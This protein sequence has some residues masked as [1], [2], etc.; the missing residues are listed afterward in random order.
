[1]TC[2]DC[3]EKYTREEIATWEEEGKVFMINNEQGVRGYLLCPRCTAKI[4][5]APFNKHTREIMKRIV[6]D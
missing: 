2:I 5:K 1:M 6:I 3:S 4:I